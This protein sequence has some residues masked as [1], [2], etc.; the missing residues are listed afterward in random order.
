MEIIGFI[1]L[2]TFIGFIMGIS[3]KNDTAGTGIIII[4]SIIW[5][6]IMGPWAIATFIEL[7]IGYSL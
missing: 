7:S 1:I 2:F 6:F 4:I 5:A 3:V